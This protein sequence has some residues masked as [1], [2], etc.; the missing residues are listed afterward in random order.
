M[1]DFLLWKSDHAIKIQLNVDVHKYY[2]YLSEDGNRSHKFQCSIPNITT[3]FV[4][5]RNFL[6]WKNVYRDYF[7]RSIYTKIGG[8]NV[9]STVGEYLLAVCFVSYPMRRQKTWRNRSPTRRGLLLNHLFHLLWCLQKAWYRSCPLGWLVS[10]VHQS[11]VSC[12]LLEC[13]NYILRPCW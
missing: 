11:F 1:F 6:R 2:Y 3:G 13:N 8:L 4:P 10:T 9:Q 5:K 12:A 7:V